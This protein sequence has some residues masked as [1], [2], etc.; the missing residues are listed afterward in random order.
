MTTGTGGGTHVV[1]QEAHRSA[2]EQARS[3]SAAIR[4]ACPQVQIGR[5]ER[6]PNVPQPFRMRD[7][8]QVARDYDA[9]AFNHQATGRFLPLIWEDHTHVTSDLDGFGL[10]TVAGDPRQGPTVNPAQHEA[11]NCLAAVIGASLVSVDKRAQDGYDYVRMCERYFSPRERGGID[12]F[13]NNVSLSPGTGSMWYFLF[14]NM[15]AFMLADVYPDHGRLEEYVRRSAD[16]L[17]ELAPAL[18]TGQWYTGYDFVR[19]E[20]VFNGRWREG[21]AVAGVAWL[22][23]MAWARFGES[24]YLDAAC[25][26]MDTLDDCDRSTF[27]E[28]L[29]PY[30]VTLAARMNAEQ[31]CDYDVTRLLNG[32]LDGDSAC[33]P[34]WGAL[35]GRWGG[36]DVSGLQ[37]SITD[38]GGYA[39]A[40]NT[41]ELVAALAP[42]P[43]YDARYA[44]AVG[45][46]ALNAANAARLFYA[47][48]L[49]P[50]NQTCYEQREFSRDV[51][52][53]EGLRRIG[54]RP[55]DAD[56]TPCA[57]GD[58]LGGRWGGHKY[59]SDFSL[60]GSSH[61]G[62]MAAV[63][64]RTDDER[65][66]QL[67]CLKADFF[68][69]EAYPTYLYYNPYNEMKEVHIDV[70]AKSA[71]LY[72]AVRHTFVGQRVSG[73]ASL[74]LPPDTAALIVLTPAGGTLTRDGSRMLIDGVIVDYDCSS[75]VGGTPRHANACDPTFA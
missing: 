3:V 68:R 42:L 63:V 31:G 47:D 67:D 59:L 66:L 17:A 70:G 54:L 8:R 60:Y 53:Y 19:H 48:S 33:R 23:Y 39:F 2:T 71:D 11:I 69:D 62:L 50:E 73:G 51:I 43:R 15:L 61:V 56:K 26:A 13:A 28:V 24:E 55:Q 20:P 64:E 41:F 75:P 21:D 40:M 72:D 7:W 12:L 22:E 34:G 25:Q 74:Q 10:Y 38:G 9:L 49:P 36:Y 6:M 1:R 32:C 44:R 27:Y 18:A 29:L 35:V 30:G 52:A 58:P 46:L 57:C 16:S 37:G 45:K 14:P 65:I 5:I 4:T